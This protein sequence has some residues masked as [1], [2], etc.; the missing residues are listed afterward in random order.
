MTNAKL[1]KQTVLVTGASS[2]I[3]Q[4]IAIAMGNAG[5]NVVINYHSDENGANK[6]LDII[7]KGGG[8]GLVIKA[9]VSRETGRR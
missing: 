6:T 4:A 7:Q 1:S 5:A 3:G 8:E 2:G 9:D